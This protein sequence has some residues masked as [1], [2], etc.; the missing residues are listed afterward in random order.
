MAR[1]QKGRVV[2]PNL[3]LAS[4][5]RGQEHKNHTPAIAKGS[6]ASPYLQMLMIHTQL[7]FLRAARRQEEKAKDG[8]RQTRPKVN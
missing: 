8:K 1:S 4:D 2:T 5:P 7:G 6:Q 3:R